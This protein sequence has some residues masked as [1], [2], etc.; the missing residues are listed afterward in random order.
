MIGRRTAGLAAA[1]VGLAAAGVGAGIS[2]RQ[3]LVV[4]PAGSARTDEPLP[5]LLG[6]LPGQ[7]RTVWTADGVPLSVVQAGLGD[8][9]VVLVH[10]YCVDRRSWHYQWAAL[11]GRARVLAYDQRSHG[12]SGRSPA[13]HAA[14]DQ[15]GRDL[16]AVLESAVPDGPIVLVGHSMG[17][18][19]VMALAEQRPEL[20]GDRVVGVALL[21]TSAGK[22]TVVTLGLPAGVGPATR[23]ILPWAV[24][25]LNRRAQLVDLSRRM[26]VDIARWVTKRYAY[27]SAVPPERVTLVTDMIGGTPFE[28][29]ADFFPAFADH[30]K[31]AALEILGK[32]RTLVVVGDGDLVTPTDHSREIAGAVPGAELLVVPRAGH[33]VMLEHPGVLNARLDALLDEVWPP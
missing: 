20:F 24:S 29:I 6:D 10:G 11:A 30:D 33:M 32:V 19:T 18:M 9:T 2:L 3:R 26:G 5:G 17:G 31:L 15:L 27:R 28:V 16:F 14:M 25:T 4:A 12:R 13:G 23:R 22:L 8:L 1:A 7:A 21:A